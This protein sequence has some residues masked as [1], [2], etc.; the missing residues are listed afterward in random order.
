MGQEEWTYASKELQKE[1]ESTSLSYSHPWDEVMEDVRFG[2]EQAMKP[3]FDGAEWPDVESEL[4]RRWEE[5]QPHSDFEDW[6]M[7]SEAV[8]L[9]FMRAKET[10][11]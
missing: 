4:Q 3:E 11:G 10:V 9:G 5:N 1:W 7:V 6:R 8:R 2:W